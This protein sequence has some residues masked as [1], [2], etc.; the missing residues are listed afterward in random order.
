M[1]LEKLAPQTKQRS[2]VCWLFPN[3]HLD[4][5]GLDMTNPLNMKGFASDLAAPIWG[6]WM[7]AMHQD[8]TV[9]KDFSGRKTQ[10]KIC[11]WCVWTI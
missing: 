5:F 6:W 3:I 1:L 10:T 7:R 11:V 2:V 9:P 4:H 8:L